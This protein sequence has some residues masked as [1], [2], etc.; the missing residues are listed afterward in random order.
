MVAGDDREPI[1]PQR[2]PESLPIPLVSGRRGEYELGSLE[3]GPFE[4][5]DI[6]EQVLRAGLA[7]DAAPAGAGGLDQ[8]CRAGAGD[9]DDVERG[10]CHPCQPYR[11]ADRLDLDA[12]GSGRRVEFRLQIA[13]RPRPPHQSVDDL[14]VLRVDHDQRP[15]GGGE[16]HRLPQG[17]VIDH[18]I[19]LVGHEELE[20]GYATV[21]QGLNFLARSLAEIANDQVEPDVDHWLRPLQLPVTRRTPLGG[22]WTLRLLGEA[23]DRRRPAEGR[24]DGPAGEVVGGALRL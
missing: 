20:T 7:E 21:D 2:L 23:D 13:L 17:S 11:A 6:G 15:V 18:Q 16:L 12:A 4:V 3:V 10:F 19:A 9:V 5:G 22:A 1:A 8:I 24:R 14:P